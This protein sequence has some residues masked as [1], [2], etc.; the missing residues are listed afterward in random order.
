MV[1]V[2]AW[3]VCVVL[4]CVGCLLCID[5]SADYD[6]RYE[7]SHQQLKVSARAGWR[8]SVHLFLMALLLT[9]FKIQDYFSIS[10]E[11]LNNTTE[12]LIT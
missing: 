10:S 3:Y 6:C 1:G 12:V 7:R 4:C 11:K 5:T 9:G 8:A 2:F